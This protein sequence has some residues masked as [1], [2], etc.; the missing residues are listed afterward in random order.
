[1]TLSKPLHKE[2]LRCFKIIQKIMSDTSPGPPY[3]N[4]SRDYQ[5]LLE[6][7]IVQ[8][9]LRDEIYVQ[10]CKQVTQNPSA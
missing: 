8:G 5:S 6:V 9:G 1:M 3:K 7:G 4:L 2:A 10:I